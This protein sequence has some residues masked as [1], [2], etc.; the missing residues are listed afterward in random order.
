ML[1]SHSALVR[2]HYRHVAWRIHASFLK[3]MA[4]QQTLPVALEAMLDV[5]SRR[6]VPEKKGCKVTRRPG[7]SSLRQ[8]TASRGLKLPTLRSQSL[9][10]PVAQR[11]TEHANVRRRKVKDD[12][13]AQQREMELLKQQNQLLESLNRQQAKALGVAK[14]DSAF[15]T[16]GLD[17]GSVFCLLSLY[18]TLTV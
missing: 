12:Q 4:A 8:P 6:A 5:A 14:G 13:Q 2:L 16:S 3:T 7:A 11:L 15:L 18:R 1:L 9:T 10:S 17:Y